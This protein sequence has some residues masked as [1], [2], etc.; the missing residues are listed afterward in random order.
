MRIRGVLQ[1]VYMLVAHDP[2]FNPGLSSL[3][4][5]NAPPFNG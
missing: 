4:L 2:I 5:D 1:I 3:V